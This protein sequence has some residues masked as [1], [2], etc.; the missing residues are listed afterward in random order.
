M[1]HENLLMIARPIVERQFRRFRISSED[2]EDVVQ[3]V[4]EKYLRQWETPTRPRNVEAWLETTT[5]HT[6]IDRARWE[7]R[8]PEVPLEVDVVEAL[9]AIH[10]SPSLLVLQ[11]KLIRQIMSCIPHDDADLL[12]RRYLDG[13][14][15]ADLAAQLGI[16]VAAVDQRTTRAKHLLREHL[17][18]HPELVDELYATHPRLY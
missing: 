7:H 12:Q 8:H 18:E 5:R 3:D 10:E 11:G 17:E 14:S 9:K 4:V 1:D 2:V 16:T 6:L 15:A 13:A